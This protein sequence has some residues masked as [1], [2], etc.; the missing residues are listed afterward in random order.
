MMGVSG[1]PVKKMLE[2]PRFSGYEKEALDFAI[3]F[4]DKFWAGKNVCF[5]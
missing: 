2:Q 3:M 5:W 1:E 4:V